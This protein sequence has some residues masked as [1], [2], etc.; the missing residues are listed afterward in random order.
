MVIS[1][2]LMMKTVSRIPAALSAPF[3]VLG[4]DE[5]R[6]IEVVA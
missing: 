1:G 5:A 6:D 2:I 3:G 4:V